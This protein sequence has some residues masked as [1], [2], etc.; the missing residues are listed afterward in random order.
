MATQEQLNAID[1]ALASGEKVIQYNG[2]RIEYRSI[3]ELLKA[4]QVVA[5]EL[6]GTGQNDLMNR[7]TVGSYSRD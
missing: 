2:K 1:A 5:A 3:D 7:M 6:N 4:R